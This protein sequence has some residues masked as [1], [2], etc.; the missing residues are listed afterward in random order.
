M[1]VLVFGH[2]DLHILQYETPTHLASCTRIH[3]ILTT[4]EKKNDACARKLLRF[5]GSCNQQRRISQR[6]F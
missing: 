3:L 1:D 4:A 2:M 6:P 5:S